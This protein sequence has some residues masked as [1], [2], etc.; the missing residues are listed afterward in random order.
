MFHINI[1]VNTFMLYKISAH[2]EKRC[3]RVKYFLYN[4]KKS[5]VFYYMFINP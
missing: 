5:E 3:A 4:S 1:F 2:I